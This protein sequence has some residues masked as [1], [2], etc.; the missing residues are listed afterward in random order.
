MAIE[1]TLAMLKPDAVERNLIGAI[2]QRIEQAGLKIV[3]MKMIQ[4]TREEA[5]AFY[6]E[7]QGM[8]FYDELVDFMQSGPVV[9][10]VLEGDEVIMDFIQLKGSTDPQQAQFGTIRH[11]FAESKRFNMIHG[12]DGRHNARREIEFFFKPDEICKR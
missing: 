8:P 2:N 12:S 3:A 9:V 5:A 7:H 10:E 6:I 1:R 4:M 11:D